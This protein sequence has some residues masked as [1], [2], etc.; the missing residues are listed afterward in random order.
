MFGFIALVLVACG[1]TEEVGKVDELEEVETT[2]TVASH[3]PPMTDIVEIAA[4]NIEAPY[5]IELMEVSDN[6]QYN[7]AVQHKEAYASFAQHEPFMEQYNEANDGNL[8][9]V[10]TIYDPIVG[11]YSPTYQSID[12]IKPE[13]EVAIPNDS[14]NEAR[15]LLILEDFE[16]IKLDENT[17][18]IDV[19]LDDIIDNPLNL[20][21]TSVDLLNLT[22]AYEDGVDLVFNYPTY[23]VNIDLTPED[24]LFLEDPDNTLFSLVLVI[25]EDNLENPD[26]KALQDAFTSQEVYDYLI[27]LSDIN[28]LYPAFD[29]PSE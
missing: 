16:L 20:E 4:D 19:T 11:F 12:E 26:T 5:S 25:H 10:Q 14:A 13:S 27:E 6:V 9:A 3:L 24:A 1:D 18:P 22:A 7:E 21:F 28:H 29:N 8:V 15:A 2:I 17:E 23:I